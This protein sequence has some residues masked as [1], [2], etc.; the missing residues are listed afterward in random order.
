MHARTGGNPFFVTE[1]LAAPGDTVPTTVRLAV[2]ARAS[3]LGSVARRV[4]DAVAVVPGRAERWLVDAMCEPSAN[5]VQECIDRGV[6]VAADDTY[7]FRHELA[8]L[9]IESQLSE[10]D[11]SRLHARALAALQARDGAD[12]ARIAHH[13][14]AAGDDAALAHAARNAALLAAARTAYRE[15]VRHGDRALS[16]RHELSAA[17]VA[18]LAV[19]L[20]PSLG[21]MMRIDEAVALADEAV[22]HW[23]AA[24]DERR[25]ADAL[26]MLSNGLAALGHTAESTPPIE[27]AIELLEHSP[28]GPEL[29]GAYA[30]LTTAHML[31]RDRDAAAEWSE[32]AIALDGTLGDD[33]LL[34][35]T[36][37]ETG[38]ADV[39][40]LRFDGLVRV[41]EGIEL[42]RRAERPGFVALGLS[43]IG[44]GCGELRRY[45]LAMPA[46]TE[47]TAY[48]AEHDLEHQR[49]YMTAWLGR[50]Q[51]D[52]GRWFEAEVH[53]RDSLAG[54]RTAAYIRFVGLNSLG[55]LRA[56][57][58]DGDV[59]PLP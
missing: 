5:A 3:R 41:H 51:F 37:I 32:R 30:R 25:E 13:A 28:P 18:E 22:E 10:A 39:M 21:A 7:P 54:P 56:R 58:G 45:D 27:R 49:P 29:A 38:I 2:L 59:W 52:L 43:H 15:A 11:R 46:L 16:L 14:E 6:L 36:M 40:D 24:G 4:L 42:A 48:A 23:R 1:A 53:C 55:W 26:V 33:G 50:C 47:G 34:A 9:A 31:A 20:G 57:R 12:P 19:R 44:T 8:R 17:E 35:R